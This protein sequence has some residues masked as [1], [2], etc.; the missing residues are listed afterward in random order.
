[1]EGKNIMQFK[2]YKKDG[3]AD[4]LFSWKERFV[5]LFKGKLHFS[6][7]NLK[8]VGNWLVKIVADWHINFNEEI[9]K[10]TTSEDKNDI[11]SSG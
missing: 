9:K 4:I 8:H 1:V 5:I 11:Q 3:S 7:L 2:Q 6:A 10:Q